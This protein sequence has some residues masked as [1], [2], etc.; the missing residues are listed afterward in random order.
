MRIAIVCLFVFALLGCDQLLHGQQQPVKSLKN[1]M[2][3]TG[4]G[5][6]VETWASCNDKAMNT[7]PAGYGVIKRD[8]NSTGTLRELTFQCKK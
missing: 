6:A 4:C 5:G 2:Y 8:E 7:C 3:F 1:N